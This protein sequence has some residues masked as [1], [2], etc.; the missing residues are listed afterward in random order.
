VCEEIF[1]EI[2][3]ELIFTVT[4]QKPKPVRCVVPVGELHYGCLIEAE[5]VAGV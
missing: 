3:L 2:F 5:C 1:S 4:R